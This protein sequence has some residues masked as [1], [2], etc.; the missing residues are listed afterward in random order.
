AIA[1]E[2]LRRAPEHVTTLGLDRKDPWRAA[3]SQLNDRSLEG[4]NR[5][6]SDI[7]R[8]LEQLNAIDRNTLSGQRAIN[9]DIVAYWLET[10]NE[11]NRQ[12]EGIS[13][14][15]YVLTQM[16]GAYASVPDFLDSKHEIETKADADAYLDRL[17]GFATAI[18]Q[19]S[20]RL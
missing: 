10:E 14:R 9:Y 4:L 18:D 12:F 20:E 2:R 7:R 5:D 16:D 17:Q 13:G 15:P 19:E 8:W 3:K 6:R 1:E 11:A